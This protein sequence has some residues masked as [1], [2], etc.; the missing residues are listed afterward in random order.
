MPPDGKKHNQIDHILIDSRQHSII[1]DVRLF[2]A[3]DGDTDHYLVVAKVTERLKHNRSLKV[4]VQ[5]PALW[6]TLIHTRT[7][8]ETG[9]E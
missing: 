4:A 3:A 5:G 9:S 1:L 7:Y 6:P 2:R 8:G